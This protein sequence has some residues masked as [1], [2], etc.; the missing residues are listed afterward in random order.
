MVNK[1]DEIINSII[2]RYSWNHRRLSDEKWTNYYERR[3]KI[4]DREA[5]NRIIKKYMKYNKVY[6]VMNEINENTLYMSYL[7]SYLVED[8]KGYI[9]KRN[10]TK[11]TGTD[12]I[13]IEEF[14]ENI[15]ENIE[16]IVKDLKQNRY[17]TKP[18]KRIYIPKTPNKERPLSIESVRDSIIERTIINQIITPITELIFS[19]ESFAYREHKSVKT[20]TK[21]VEDIVLNEDIKYALSIDIESFF[22]NI[23]TDKL[24]KM[25]KDIVDDRRFLKVI[26]IIIKTKYYDTRDKKTYNPTKGLYQ[27]AVISPTLAN[28]YLHNILDKWY[29]TNILTEERIYMARYADDVLILTKNYADAIKAKE[30]ISKRFK[31]YD[32]KMSDEKTEIINLDEQELKYLGYTIK[33]KGKYLYKYISEKTINKCND[34]TRSFIEELVNDAKYSKLLNNKDFD[35]VRHTYLRD[36]NDMLIGMYSTY[37]DI[38]NFDDLYIVYNFAIDEL[39]H[40]YEDNEVLVNYLEEDIN[41]I[42][43]PSYLNKVIELRRKENNLKNIHSTYY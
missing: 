8:N 29:S 25:L 21:Y 41:F 19:A 5:T 11:A 24:L 27:G 36:I 17:E 31:D 14:G 10:I 35:M 23:N 13:S 38:D 39:K 30:E 12:R 40:R 15:K 32:L 33:K 28:L 26:E 4:I 7:N 42:L 2:S 34:K 20:A 3:I 18:I 37:R 1:K 16:S 6:S 22:D 9:H 43:P